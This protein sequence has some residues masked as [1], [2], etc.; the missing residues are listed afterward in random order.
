MRSE[1]PIMLISRL[2]FWLFA[3]LCIVVAL[4]SYRFLVLGFE[5][6]FPGLQAHIAYRKL[7]FLLHI[8]ASPVALALGVFQFMPRLR[9]KRLSLHRWTGRVYGLAVL[10]GGLSG[11]A[12]AIGSTERPVAAAGF[13]I[14]ALFWVSITA[15]AVRMAMTGRVAEHRRWM[16]RSMALT[17]AAVTLRLE[18]P[19]FFIFGGMEY[20]E[21][22]NYVA[23]LCWVPN[24]LVAEWI[25][26][27]KRG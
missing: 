18:L 5:I 15:V 6:S 14:L 11:L 4:V 21:A 23:W 10:I 3:A 16:I 24:L 20:A 8:L 9:A 22:S 27:H 1:V 7:S 12:L 2:S 17:F 25:I 19:L 13:G 26:R